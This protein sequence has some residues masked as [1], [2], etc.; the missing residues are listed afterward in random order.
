MYEKTSTLF[1][2]VCLCFFY[3][4]G[5]GWEWRCALLVWNSF[6]F[7]SHQYEIEY[8]IIDSYQL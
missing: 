7:M 5:G 2:L 6:K 8:F 3:G 1:L 4:G